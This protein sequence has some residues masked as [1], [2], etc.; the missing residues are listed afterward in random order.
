MTPELGAGLRIHR[1]Q[2]RLEEPDDL[3]DS[4]NRGQDGGGMGDLLVTG[5]P[6]DRA[7]LDVQGHQAFA[8]ATASN[9]DPAIFNHR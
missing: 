1:D 7:R 6:E 9:K 5:L 4:M 2:S 8:S 3:T